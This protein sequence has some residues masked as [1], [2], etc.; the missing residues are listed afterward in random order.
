MHHSLQE[1]EVNFEFCS[2][3][4]QLKVKFRALTMLVIWSLQGRTVFQQVWPT[5]NHQ[6]KYQNRV[7][8]LN[9]FSFFRFKALKGQSH[10]LNLFSHYINHQLSLRV[11]P[12]GLCNLVPRVFS[13]FKMAECIQG[14]HIRSRDTQWKEVLFCWQPCP[15]VSTHFESGKAPGDE[16]GKN[17]SPCSLRD[18]SPTK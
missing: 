14:C 8:T 15:G 11:H 16:A 1:F 18:G 5:L 6:N 12:G 10:I 4:E 9:V 7:I 3:Q 13:T 17:L 2:K